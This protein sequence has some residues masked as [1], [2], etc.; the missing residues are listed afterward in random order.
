MRPEL[1]D[2]FPGERRDFIQMAVILFVTALEAFLSGA[3][4]V[5]LAFSKPGEAAL[6]LWI[7]LL[8]GLVW[9]FMIFN[10]DRYMVLGMEGLHRMRAVGPAIIRIVL[11]VLIGFVMSTPIVL[12][13][14]QSEVEAKVALINQERAK[15]GT[16]ELKPFQEAVDKATEVVD[17]RQQDVNAAQSG[18]S[19]ET[20]PG[21]KA[22]TD[23]WKEATNACTLAQSKATREFRGELPKSEG[24]T[25]KPG[26][27]EV[28]RTFQNQADAACK[29]AD[30]K[31]KDLETAKQKAQRTPQQLAAAIQA[32]QDSLTIALDDQ[33]KVIKARNEAQDRFD[34]SAQGYG[35]LIRLEAL[36]RISHD[37]LMAG[38]AHAFLVGLLASIEI[39]PVLF[40]VLKQWTPLD[41]HG[42]LQLSAY[43]CRWRDMDLTALERGRAIE[44]NVLA[45]A[46]DASLQPIRAAEVHQ[47]EQSAVNAHIAHEIAAVQ[48]EVMRRQLR[49]W[50]ERHR[51]SYHETPFPPP[52]GGDF[53][54]PPGGD[55]PPPPGGD[56]PP[57][58]GGDFPPPPGG[59][60]PS[61]FNTPTASQLDDYGPATDPP[62]YGPTSWTPGA[63][64]DG[65]G[66]TPAEPAPWAD[67]QW[68]SIDVVAS[69]PPAAV[70]PALPPPA[71]PQAPTADP[72]P[73]A[74]PVAD[75]EQRP[76]WP[77]A[78]RRN[79][80][81]EPGPPTSEPVSS[82]PESP[83]PSPSAPPSGYPIIGLPAPD[84]EAPR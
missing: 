65:Y 24:G 64:S 42:N 67:N 22:A 32:A 45:A 72:P 82:T 12:Q 38:I 29:F 41:S 35:V 56:F 73:S 30:D 74:A 1:I 36:S 2:E 10:I 31:A 43:E 57:P 51:V 60:F 8:S 18:Y 63:H 40:K 23:A 15:Q 49:A 25:E 77:R 58:P 47:R 84:E 7:I 13:L 52:P 50:A 83:Y 71:E 11:A 33:A 17:K 34:R 20:D 37:N 28:Y 14:F 76:R 3:F 80:T 54:P 6:P 27:S 4:A 62:A 26:A 46:R 70:E 19:L 61:P 48:L 75:P 21:Y 5:N 69:P 66:Q 79:P 39:L 9:A 68:P 81:R 59:D 44:A 16:D 55:F 53:P 78:S